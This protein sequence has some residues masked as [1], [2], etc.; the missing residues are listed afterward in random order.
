MRL[1]LW[2]SWPFR[3]FIGGWGMDLNVEVTRVLGKGF[4]MKMRVDED[5][6][7]NLPTDEK[8]GDGL[9]IPT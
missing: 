9:L 1:W 7:E 6:C 4:F 5:R 3:V 8:N 2:S